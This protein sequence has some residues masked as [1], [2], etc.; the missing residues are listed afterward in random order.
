MKYKLIIS[1]LDNTLLSRSREISQENVDAIREYIQRGGVFTVSSGRM[2]ES[3][4]FYFRKIGLYDLDMPVIGCNGSII[5][6]IKSKKV[7]FERCMPWEDV[8][9]ICL[10]CERL[11]VYF[12][13]YTRDRLLV[14]QENPINIE[15]CRICHMTMHS[16]GKLSDYVLSNHP[17]IHKVLIALEPKDA[18]D[19]CR[20]M[21]DT[22]NGVQFFMT[23]EMFVEAAA[24]E[25]GKGNAVRAMRDILGISESEIMGIGDNMNDISMLEAVGNAIAVDN[26]IDM[27][28]KVADHITASC[29]DSGVAR[30]I[31]EYA[32]DA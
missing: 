27:V 32:L 4:E 26:A 6:T 20:H 8:Y 3:L 22:F 19:M 14:S 31:R 10:E 13:I 23:C 18:P 30:A 15:Y 17:D 12:H 2:P 24:L 16:V 28:K 1:D 21:Q 7:L 11:G 29:D 25:A 5:R 9:K